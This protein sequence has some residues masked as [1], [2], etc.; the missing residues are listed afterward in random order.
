MGM[1]TDSTD[2]RI[3]RL[4]HRLRSL[5]KDLLP[6][7]H[8][9]MVW[10]TDPVHVQDAVREVVKGLQGGEN[11]VN[12]LINLRRKAQTPP[13]DGMNRVEWGCRNIFP[14]H[15][16]LSSDSLPG[17]A[18]PTCPICRGQLVNGES[19]FANGDVSQVGGHDVRAEGCRRRQEHARHR[20]SEQGGKE[21]KTNVAERASAR[22]E[23]HQAQLRQML[24]SVLAK[25]D[26]MYSWAM[27]PE[28]VS[29]A[30]LAVSR[31][32]ERGESPVTA[33]ALLARG[34]DYM[35]RSD[36][37]SFCRMIMGRA[38]DNATE[39]KPIDWR[40][41]E[42]WMDDVLQ[43]IPELFYDRVRAAQARISTG[44]ELYRGVINRIS[45]ELRDLARMERE[46]IAI[47]WGVKAHA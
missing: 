3:Q 19:E 33:L 32:M 42:S 12:T 9:L 43:E 31:A 16:H 26:R 4:Q 20:P 37:V 36:Q 2:D 44:R 25:G 38:W 40:G 1:D 41:G 18:S 11:P 46:Q 35:S 15:T 29:N 17:G 22:I 7:G 8:E 28:H 30:L 34:G 10:G 47:G 21:A 14:D 13:R 5:T 24:D 27:D 6:D 23:R 39:V 45:Q